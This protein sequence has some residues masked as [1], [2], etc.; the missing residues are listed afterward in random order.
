MHYI[1]HSL[2]FFCINVRKRITRLSSFFVKRWQSTS[3]SDRDLIKSSILS[4]I[5]DVCAKNGDQGKQLLGLNK[6][7]RV[8]LFL[9]DV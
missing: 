5:R 7:A 1:F 8:S 6:K 3:D 9:S 4:Y 2:F